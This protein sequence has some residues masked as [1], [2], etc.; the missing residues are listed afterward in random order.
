MA[1]PRVM[2]CCSITN[3]S[4]TNCVLLCRPALNR[5]PTAV[6]PHSSWPRATFTLP[7]R[8][9]EPG[10]I[11]RYL[12]TAPAVVYANPLIYATALMSAPQLCNFVY[13]NP[14]CPNVSTACPACAP[15]YR[16]QLLVTPKAD[17]CEE[18]WAMNPSGA[19][20]NSSCGGLTTGEPYREVG[21]GRGR[22]GAEWREAGQGGAC[23]CVLRG[24][25]RVLGSC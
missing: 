21:G 11:Y 20:T 24:E 17:A 3:S 23:V 10:N 19:A 13:A 7:P 15:Y 16:A 22:G 1:V 12:T 25:G 18:F 9:S 4:S 8:L 14:H 6:L 5:P 2:L